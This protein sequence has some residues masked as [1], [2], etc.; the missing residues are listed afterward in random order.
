MFVVREKGPP[1]AALSVSGSGKPAVGWGTANARSLMALSAL[2]LVTAVLGGGGRGGLGDVLAQLLAIALLTFLCWHGVRGRLKWRV[3][4]WVLFLPGLALALPLLQ[5]LPIPMEWWSFPA[6]RAEL[7]LQMQEV[8]VTPLG[9][10]SLN[11]SATEQALWSLLPAT[12]LFLSI[13]VMPSRD[14][15]LVLAFILLLAFISLTMGMAQLADGPQSQLRLYNPTNASDAVG[16]FANRNHLACFLAMCLPFAL[17]GSFWTV[18]EAV[19][20]RPRFSA[21]GLVGCGL[22]IL[23]LLGIALTRSRGGVLL[24]MI[25]A[26][27]CLPMVLGVPLERGTRRIMALAG[28]VAVLLAIQFAG[29]GVLQRLE[30]DPLE[31]GRWKYAQVTREAAAAYSPLGSGLGTFRQAYQPFEAKGGV[32]GSIVN[33]AHNDYLELWLEGGLPAILLMLAFG[34]VWLWR[35]GQLWLR[36]ANRD[37]SGPL[38]ILVSRAA[39]LSASLGLLHSALDYPLRTTANM[40]VF[41]VL[42][43][44][45]FSATTIGSR[46]GVAEISHRRVAVFGRP[47]PDSLD[48]E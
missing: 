25:A 13:L 14:R 11:P 5:L 3:E 15:L 44:I 41:A 22:A 4:K 45:S 7:A 35:G 2:L 1:S 46:R 17:V 37:A 21:L 8:G 27:G 6:A 29:V 47:A 48:G 33:H 38:A 36:S 23:I 12:A 34:A 30:S 20:G 40:S 10:I 42:V 32:E 24:A 19:S 16:F 26:V 28:L 43:A 9:V 31:D 18:S 39:W